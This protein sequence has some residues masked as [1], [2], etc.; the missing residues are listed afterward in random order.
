MNNMIS[1]YED[2]KFKILVS[3]SLG[4][5]KDLIVSKLVEILET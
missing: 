1:I 4:E 3:S 2:A 5:H